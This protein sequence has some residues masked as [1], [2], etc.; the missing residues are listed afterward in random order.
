[1]KRL[2]FLAIIFVLA[3]AIRSQE[4]QNVRLFV[5]LGHTDAINSVAYSPDGK[6]LASAGDKSVRLWDAATFTE[7][8]NLTG[9]TGDVQSVGFSPDGK[10]LVSGSKDKTVI[11]W[12]VASGVLLRR[13]I[14]HTGY[15]E[16]VAFEP[17]GKRIA[18]GSNDGTVRFW[19]V[20]TGD[21]VTR[22]NSFADNGISS[23]A[24]DR[25]GKTIAVGSRGGT[26]EIWDVASGERLKKI[27]GIPKD[28]N[29]FMPIMVPVVPVA[30]SPKDN[31]IAVGRTTRDKDKS[32]RLLEST[33]A[34]ESKKMGGSSTDVF[35]LAFAPDGKTL[36]SAGAEDAIRFWNVQTG[37]QSGQI[38]SG[39]EN[40]YSVAFS[41]DGKTLA[42]GDSGNTI[43][44]WD[45]AS[46]KEIK[47]L[48]G[49]ETGI[50]LA[51]IGSGEKIIAG[52][53]GSTLIWD[54]KNSPQPRFIKGDL[55]AV[56]RDEMLALGSSNNEIILSDIDGVTLK[57]IMPVGDELLAPN[58]FS[59]DGKLLAG[60]DLFDDK[61][62]I[63]SAVTGR[64][65]KTLQGN[66]NDTLS[67]VAFSPDGKIIAGIGLGVRV[68]LWDTATGKE[69]KA[70][71]EQEGLSSFSS[72]TFG[73]DGKVLAC[74]SSDGTIRLLDGQTAA[75]VK[76]LEIGKFRRDQ[77]ADQ[78]LNYS[79][80]DALVFSHDG[81]ILASGSSD[82]LIRFWDVA[83]G[84]LLR[85][86]NGHTGSVLSLDFSDNDRILVSG[87][88][89][90]TFRIWNSETG[91]QLAAIIALENN[92]WVVTTPE[93]RFDTNKPLEEKAALHWVVNDDIQH[94]VSL[95]AYIRQYYEPN[96]LTRALK[97]ND[98][99]SCEK[100]FKPLPPIGAINRVR[101]L[102]AKSAIRN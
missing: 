101:P 15:V 32:I 95:D 44:I 8:A 13:I 57:T 66:K 99:G 56:S 71:N 40:I 83:T 94:P 20:I 28:P 45:F 18:S 30:V 54:W 89:D 73:P 24:F 10:T 9:H 34:V 11:V 14:G 26:F 70:Q 51:A 12:D 63:W 92:Q 87:G 90:G 76:R 4:R 31:L 74:G 50:G 69:R 6:L 80:T 47:K 7:L 33:T 46:R 2:V 19:D 67:S 55:S 100:E 91:E 21:E 85:I 75:E 96:L 102:L 17:D 58:T 36:A 79:S 98:E 53:N 16:S 5:E 72:V 59:P 82:N 38:N 62:L 64:K 41:P 81:K 61:V 25:D 37:E 84:K 60:T 68:R 29:S 42:A 88:G 52:A 48:S 3:C 49:H 65:A 35:A 78:R 27:D 93:G 39:A 23:I 22:L 43:H 77:S 1:M 97:C 86:L